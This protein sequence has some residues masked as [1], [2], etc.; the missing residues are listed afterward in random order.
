MRLSILF[1]GI[2][3][4]FMTLPNAL[5]QII[6]FPYSEKFD[7]SASLPA[8]WSASGF[9]INTSSSS[10]HSAPNAVSATGNKALKTIT[11]PPFDFSGKIPDTLAF[12]ERR[13]ATASKERLAV[14]AARG[15]T[16]FNLLLCQFDS[17]TTTSSYVKRR[18]ALSQTG[19]RFQSQVRFRWEIL[20]DSTNSTGVVRLDDIALTTAIATDVSLSRIYF[21]PAQPTRDDSLFIY[22]VVKNNGLL[23]ANAVDVVFYRNQDS[24]GT[25]S[26]ASLASFDSALCCLTVPHLDAGTETFS[27]LAICSGDENHSNDTASAAVSVQ[28]NRDD[29]VINEIMFDPLA[30]QDEWFEIYNR[31]SSA[32]S[33]K[34]WNFHDRPSLSGRMKTCSLSCAIPS[35]NFLCI[36][37][38]SSLF[39]LFSFSSP[40]QFVILNQSGGF[41]LNNDSDAVVLCDASGKVIDSI[42]YTADWHNPGIK[43]VSGRS[44]ERIDP[45]GASNSAGNWSTCSDLYGGTPGKANSILRKTRQSET[46]VTVAPNP[47]SPDGDGFEDVCIIK[48]QLPSVSAMI[49]AR[50]FDIKGRMIRT[51]ANALYSA[52]NGEISWDGMDNENRRARIGVYI[53]LLEASDPL[54]GQKTAYKS[55]IVVAGRR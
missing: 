26:I 28:S 15:D 35:K 50:L 4:T 5:A 8:G 52:G 21:D 39:A 29:I 7:S 6:T 2:V 46:T 17:T 45:D 23:P 53:L 19:L 43:D 20:R 38:D 24:I 16:N 30:G 36:A 27:A 44:L 40:D 18:I 48:F 14:F 13:S 55:A 9:T 11:S 47:F 33:L 22:A 31:T 25:V 42:A 51:I 1:L 10:S 32:V 12:Y 3:M 49:T 41:S 37:A 34:G 54:S